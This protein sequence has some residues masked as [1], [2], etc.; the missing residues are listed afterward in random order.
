MKKSLKTYLKVIEE[1]KNKGMEGLNPYPSRANTRYFQRTFLQC[2]S[3]HFFPSRG[4]S[5]KGLRIFWSKVSYFIQESIIS[6]T[7]GK[8]LQ[9]K[10]LKLFQD[11]SS[12]IQEAWILRTVS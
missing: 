7:L 8:Q 1:G 5:T 3:L 10:T 9:I 6:I 12:T 11:T 2:C 4:Y